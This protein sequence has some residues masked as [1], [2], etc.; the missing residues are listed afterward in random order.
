MIGG[1]E[2]DE[3]RVDSRRLFEDFKS[4]RA[5]L[6]LSDLTL[7]ELEGAPS[8]V[9]AVLDQVPEAHKEIVTYLG[10]TEALAQAYVEAGAVGASS[11]SDAVHVALATLC[12]AVVLVSWNFKHMVNWQRIQSYNQVNVD[13]GHRPI[14]IRTPREIVDDR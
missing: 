3:F 7:R 12:G 6:V 10:E 9:R 14:D 8:R 1:C 4:G 13:R 11:R 2:D 5:T